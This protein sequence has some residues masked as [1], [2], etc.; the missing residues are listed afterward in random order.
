[1]ES[2]YIEG[3]YYDDLQSVV[4]LT[5]QWVAVNEKSKNAVVVQSRE[6]TCFSWSFVVVDSY[7]CAGK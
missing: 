6:A 1:M 3:M 7:R 4:Q 2:L 5:Q